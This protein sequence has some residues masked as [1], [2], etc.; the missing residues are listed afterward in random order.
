MGN[1]V[2]KSLPEFKAL[3]AET[4][5]NSNVLAAK[6]GVW[7]TENNK[8]GI[9]P[10]LSE[11]VGL[12]NF[13]QKVNESIA[14]DQVTEGVNENLKS[15]KEN[16]EI[17]QAM[18]NFLKSIGVKLE[19]VS[20]IRNK[21]GKIIDAVAKA[22]MVKRVVQVVNGR[23]SVDTLPEEAAHFFVEL[24][25]TDGNP[26]FTAMMNNIEGYSIYDEVVNDPRYQEAYEGDETKLK[27]EA[28]GKLIAQQLVKNL[29][30]KDSPAK[31][32]RA[33]TWFERVMQAIRKFFSKASRSP[34]SRGA[35]IMLSEKV[36]E[37]LNVEDNIEK[38]E[39]GEYYEMSSKIVDDP[40]KTVE[41]KLD[42]TIKNYESA[43]V[44]AE[45]NGF[46]EKWI[47][48]EGSDE[49]Q[50]YVGKVGSPF[51][52]VVIRGRVSDEVKKHFRNM[53]G[54]GPETEA[55][56]SRRKEAQTIRM[57]TGTAGHHTLEDLINLKTNNLKTTK[58]QI[59]ANS[60][61]NK[62]QF[63]TLSKGV[64][65]I[66]K[67]V[68]EEQD[69]INKKNGTKGKAIFRTEQI[70]INTG[71]D[72]GG[73]IDLLVLFNDGSAAVYD[74][75]FVSPSI[76]AGY[77]DRKTGK[78]VNDPFSVKM[79]TYN[80][81]IGAYKQTLLNE[82][83]VTKVRQSRIVPIH[84]RY[85]YN[86]EKQRIT[87]NITKIQM[88]TKYSQFLEQIPVAEEMTDFEKINDVITKLIIRKKNVEDR[89]KNK[90][91][92]VGETFEKAK[93]AKET[94]EKQLRKLQLNQDVA[95][96]LN[97]L[98]KDLKDL[99]KRV[100]E[101]EP[102]TEKGE[103]NPDYLTLDELND[104]NNDLI[105]YR[106][107]LRLD[108]YMTNLRTEDPTKYA[109][110][111][112]IQKEVGT[113]IEIGQSMVE[114]KIR[115]RVA[116]NARERGVKGIE[117][118]N[119]SIDYM[120][121]AFVTLSKQNNPFLRNLY[122]IVDELNYDKRKAVKVVAAEIQR[123][124]DAVLAQSST[125]GSIKAFDPLIN[126]AT[127]NFVPKFQKEFYE[128]RDKAIQE[129]NSRWFEENTVINQENYDKKFKGY[130]DNKKKL[131]KRKFTDNNKAI[132]R[133]LLA[134]DKQHDIVKH[135]K[136]ASVSLGGKYFLKADE[137]FLTSEYLKIQSN[138]ALK[139]FYEYYQDKI[140]VIEEMFGKSL[141]TGF[142]A[143]IQK[144]FVES[145]QADGFFNKKGFDSIIEKTQVR[146]HDLSLGMRDDN[147]GKLIRK[148]PKL[149]ITPITDGNG[150]VDPSL[151]SRDLGKGLLLLFDAALDYQMKMEVMPE[152]MAM[153]QL[154]KD[155]TIK[156]ID[157]DAFGN[158]IPTLS[159]ITRKLFETRNNAD[160]FTGYVD[161][162]FFGNTVGTADIKIGKTST[163]KTALQLKQFHSL[164]SLGLKMPVAAGA[165]FAGQFGLYQ[166]AAKNRFI[167]VKS[168]KTSQAALMKADPKI[169]AIA[170]YFDMYQR[171]DAKT[172]ASK[173]SANYVTRHLTNDKWFSFLST[174]DRGIDATISHSVAQ[175]MGLD[176]D[177]NEI[178]RLSQ[179]PEGTKS[180][181]DLMEI[182]E[183]PQWKGTAGN[184]SNKAV[185]R[186]IV[187]MPG[188][189]KK[190][191]LEFRNTAKRVS[192][193]V[194]GTMSDEDIALY[195]NTLLM[196]FMMHY[197]SWLPGVAME[198]FGKQ[199]YDQI[200]KTFDEGTW[201]STFN[202]MGISGAMNSKEALD[203][204]VG[205]LGYIGQAGKDIA[206]IGIDVATFG[207][208]D[209]FKVKEDLARAKFEQWAANNKDNPEFTEKLKDPEQ[210]E[211]MFKDFVD[212]KRGNIKAN[213]MEM[214]LTML[215]MLLLM[216]MG[217]DYDDD[218]KIDIR[219]SRAGRKLYA[220]TNRTYRELAVFTQ[221]QE[222]LESGR[223]TGIPLLTLGG[224]LFKLSSNTLDEMR[225]DL[226]DED[227]KR[228]KTER[229]HYTF[230][231]LPGLNAL[232][233]TLE[234]SEGDKNAR[235]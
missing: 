65:D 215:F 191:E 36:S 124:Q 88:G 205:L 61:F 176:P 54:R 132:E 224:Q 8:I 217:G 10:A 59:L 223:A 34:Y 38:L 152:V 165:F 147:T 129:G 153:E 193:K 221:P 170:E 167:T 91:F 175:N 9:F 64:D 19:T 202:N 107:L 21:N 13:T 86:K 35:Y 179:L 95:Y 37:Y 201:I 228:D 231:M 98:K 173:L 100:Q 83:G 187:T 58:A 49:L 186:Y 159:G 24:L 213:I 68:N 82:Y 234:F 197:K 227:S 222:F 163:I 104:L 55:E 119:P 6:I 180:I 3:A 120:T 56:S 23:A 74:Y 84:I 214:R 200:L 148:I 51:E 110:T 44:S 92:Q 230:K 216:A 182:K 127:G 138:P 85:E 69:K 171:D 45:K 5:I 125:P 118:Y 172:R 192:D 66:I 140:R 78:I 33:N 42:E 139:E 212:M 79:D 52:G 188:M 183:N 17:D 14:T 195:N 204:E 160:V 106:N 185:D 57:E 133:E 7:Q 76:E 134:W 166:Q 31:M 218:G 103:P 16:E 26:L 126:N 101:N 168:L 114:T 62:T 39:S 181:L 77:V 151:K 4:G 93:L 111:I 109:K 157:T 89:L 20:K 43:T 48:E 15:Q 196:R 50:R 220:I 32:K 112:E 226:L 144:E 2:N 136:T 121:G 99:E 87:R 67:Q 164:I 108:D 80:I 209:Q 206:R 53:R 40:R 73:T 102:L 155:N 142:I 184:V 233:K 81:Q 141:G 161:Q 189:T 29:Q 210:K 75:K 203:K 199:R 12:E 27:K 63:D 46:K 18:N 143:E 94:M 123:L 60:P 146:E 232:T 28:V 1:C 207:L 25:Q 145:Q 22:D 70:I 154:L 208:T 158:V 235:T 135:F 198:R 225:D 30:G 131:L 47:V 174:A 130:R 105:F 97:G 150:N 128:S 219:Q 116:D 177:T 122:G 229:F 117:D 41:Q 113:S 149:F 11:L 90:N 71:K 190:Q 211:E 178:K 137:K 72:T 169:R 96:V 162:Y 194:K 115:D 156:E